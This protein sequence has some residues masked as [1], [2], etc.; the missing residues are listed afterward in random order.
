MKAI[1]LLAIL[2][3]LLLCFSA[4]AAETTQPQYA[5]SFVFRNGITWQSNAADIIAAEGQEPESTGSDGAGGESLIWEPASVSNYSGQLFYLLKDDVL[6]GAIYSF[7]ELPVE[8]AAYHLSV[9]LPADTAYL[10]NALSSKYGEPAAVSKERLL[11]LLNLISP[12]GDSEVSAAA[13]WELADGTYI[14]AFHIGDVFFILYCNEAPFLEAC[15]V[16]NTSGL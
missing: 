8:G 10:V 4:A 16:Y 7:S 12:V 3:A 6:Y 1:R 13:N 9:L 14:A 5:D 15:G 2:C 11:T